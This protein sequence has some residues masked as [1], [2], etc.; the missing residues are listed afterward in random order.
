MDEESGRVF[1]EFGC[2]YLA[3][4]GGAG[5]LAAKGIKAVKA[6]HWGDLGMAEAVWHFGVEDFGPLLVAM[7]AKGGSLY[8]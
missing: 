7:D 5:A 6:V 3:F 1:E 8:K 2:V 4:T